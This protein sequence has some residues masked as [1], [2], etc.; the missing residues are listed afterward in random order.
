M[1]DKTAVDEE[2][3]NAVAALA[4]R[5]RARDAMPPEERPDPE[6]AAGEFIAAL[7]LRGWRPTPALPQAEWR[8]QLRG[9]GADPKRYEALLAQVK[10]DC[11]RATARLMAAARGPAEGRDHG[12]EST[13][14]DT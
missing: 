4:H 12:E 11:R 2:T 10:A 13:R 8:R 6:Y 9:R 7:R 3:R 14:E 5:L 1:T